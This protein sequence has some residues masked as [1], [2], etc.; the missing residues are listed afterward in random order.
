MLRKR[1]Q[2]RNTAKRFRFLRLASKVQI[3][4]LERRVMLSTTAQPDFSVPAPIL[5][6]A[7]EPLQGVVGTPN[8]MSPSIFDNTFGFSGEYYTQ[9]SNVY[10]AQGAYQTIAIVDAYGSPTLTN[11]VEQ[12]DSYWGVSNFDANGKFFLTIQPLAPTVNTVVDSSTKAGWAAETALDVEWAHVVAPKA[13][14]LLVAAP[15]DQFLDLLDANVYAAAQPGVVVVSN[16]WYVPDDYPGFHGEPYIEDGYFVTPTGHIDSNG[17]AG[18]VAFFAAS[19]DVYGQNAYP[20]ESGNVIPV[21]G[22]TIGTTINGDFESLG[23]W[24]NDLGGTGGVHDGN[25]AHPNYNEPLVSLDADPYTGVWTYNTAYTGT[26][27]SVVGGTSLA[28]PTWAAYTAIVDQGLELEGLPSVNSQYIAGG[29]GQNLQYLISAANETN[30][31]LADQTFATFWVGNPPAPNTYPLWPMSQPGPTITVTPSNNNT[32]WGF[33]QA[34]N[35][36]NFVISGDVSDHFLDGASASTDYLEF[37]DQPTDTPAGSAISPVEVEAISPTTGLVD[38]GASGSVTLSLGSAYTNTSTLQGTVVE[39]FVNG[40]ATFS[41]LAIDPMGSYALFASSPNIVPEESSGFVI[42]NAAASQ[43]V[44]QE[45]PV[46]FVETSYMA[47]PIIMVLQDQFGNIVS[48][49]GTT[50]TLSIYSGPSGAVLSG[51]TSAVT[52]GGVAIFNKV[53]ASLPGDY[54]L[55]ATAGGLTSPATVSFSV[56]VPHLTFIEQPASIYEYGAMHTTVEVAVEDQNGNVATLF[57]SVPVTLSIESGPPGSVLSSTAGI[58]TARTVNG[59]ATFAGLVA[60]I[61]GTDTLKATSPDLSN[62]VSDA[63]EVVPV[64]VTQRYLFNGIGLSPNTILLQ[65]IRNAQIYT[66]PPTNLEEEEF[67]S[68]QS[69][70]VTAPIESTTSAAAAPAAAASTFAAGNP[71]AS[72]TDSQFLDSTNSTDRKLLN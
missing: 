1:V 39:S 19:G 14:I 69:A 68:A 59:I 30:I 13:H 26:G 43:I 61:P 72:T 28:S 5:P 37:L 20:A 40:I 11:D 66:T 57:P 3:E 60:N 70:A 56:E 12:F 48:T 10:A 42:G 16:S 7:P 44:I 8:S 50:V 47:T 29:P 51:Q 49:S 6:T 65:Q 9:G 41:D 71:P 54:K 38:T 2:R 53:S 45:Q 55:V 22:L 18:G 25:Y 17:D 31:N 34:G 36:G 21:G 27:W 63:F 52:S 58:T 64:P 32:G 15:S 46:S 23:S 67:L 35:F 33:P 62:G 4:V 24:S